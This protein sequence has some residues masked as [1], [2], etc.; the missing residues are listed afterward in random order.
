[1]N[2]FIAIGDKVINLDLVTDMSIKKGGG[3]T[4][5]LAAPSTDMPGCR[6]VNFDGEDAAKLR[7]W[8]TLKVPDIRAPMK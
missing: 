5:Y 7:D 6:V 1:M 8:I 2:N 3:I 4:L